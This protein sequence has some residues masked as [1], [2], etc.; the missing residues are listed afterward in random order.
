MQ[1]TLISL[2]LSYCLVAKMKLPLDIMHIKNNLPC[3]QT[4][5]YL[6]NN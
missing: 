4:V 1:T 3:I 5:I 2:Q 6:S